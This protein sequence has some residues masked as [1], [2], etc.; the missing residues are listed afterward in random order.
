MNAD[1]MTGWPDQ[2]VSA[3]DAVA[4]IQSGMRVFVHGAAATPTPL[5]DA[6]VRHPGRIITQRQ[7]LRDVWGP[8]A[9]EQTHYLRVY[10]NLLRKKLGDLLLIRNEPGIGYR[11]VESL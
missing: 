1:S 11:I 9:E 4:A 7:L 3:D 5:L 6:L 10:A 2:A 8:Q